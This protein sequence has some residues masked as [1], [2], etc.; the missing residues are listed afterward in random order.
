MKMQIMFKKYMFKICMLK[1]INTDERN[2]RK[3]KQLHHIH[4]TKDSLLILKC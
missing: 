1:T 4:E 2:K 3:C